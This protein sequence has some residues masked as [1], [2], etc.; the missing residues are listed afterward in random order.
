MKSEKKSE[1]IVKPK[2]SSVLIRGIVLT[3]VPLVLLV[4]LSSVFS[5]VLFQKQLR[6]N[7]EMVLE[8][9]SDNI[10]DSLGEAEDYLK[11]TVG[12]STDFILLNNGLTSVAAHNAAYNLLSGLKQYVEVSSMVE[13]V[14]LYSKE[15]DICRYCHKAVVS[16]EENEKLKKFLIQQVEKRTLGTNWEFCIIDNCAYLIRLLGYER[17]ALMSYVNLSRIPLP[18]GENIKSIICKENGIALNENTFLEEH[19]I[20]ENLAAQVGIQ[21]NYY[22][23][24]KD[25]KGIDLKIALVT[26]LK[27][28][29][30]GLN[31]FQWLIIILSIISIFVIPFNLRLIH[32][33]IKV[34][35]AHL[36]F[37]MQEI[38]STE[39]IIDEQE[40][41]NSQEFY[42]IYRTFIEMVARLKEL[43]IARYEME[44][45]KKQANLQYLQLQLK[46][47][48]FINCLKTIFAMVENQKYK[49]IQQM[50]IAV[51]NYLRYNLKENSKL[52]T[53]QE[54]INLV[55]N[56]LEI[57]KLSSSREIECS[58]DI[59]PKL[60]EYQVPT[61]V[62][63]TFV[64]NSVKYA[65]IQNL[66]IYIKCCLLELE[67][68]KLINIIVT[69][70]G[71]G[72]SKEILNEIDK[73]ENWRDGY[74]VGIHNLI[75]R[76]NILYQSK[77][78]FAFYNEEESSGAISEIYI[79]V[80]Q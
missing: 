62:I 50:T 24:I 30:Y 23:S 17:V 16:W 22:V 32:N 64:E 56:Y 63:Q 2:I 3:L 18:T 66:E 67:N 27:N 48:F 21:K 36:E 28:D 74:C 44:L 77:A 78:E 43:R 9:Y 20:E 45:E 65:N 8:L 34:P 37:L 38:I 70:N 52:V 54:E 51:S 49:K 46:P 57:Q 1:Y 26:L 6:R 69:D 72:Y 29:F 10:S 42:D 12:E 60:L 75:Q 11:R 33:Y 73:K 71:S 55:N 4:N 79:P 58:M 53:L 19:K 5:A 25:I 68:E 31:F 80:K 40:E 7:S 59:D 13:G 39:K 61:F 15:N 14:L 76:T 41:Y 47:H 35:L